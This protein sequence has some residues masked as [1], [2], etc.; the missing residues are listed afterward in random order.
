MTSP[1]DP[2]TAM[3]EAAVA[4][5]EVFKSYV[6]AGFTEAQALT[7]VAAMVTAQM[8]GGSSE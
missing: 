4:L 1:A 8:Q 7:L 6:K 3:A 2:L 5:H